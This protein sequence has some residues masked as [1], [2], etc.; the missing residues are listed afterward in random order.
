M[1]NE[2]KRRPRRFWHNV[3]VS[4]Y[5]SIVGRPK[6]WFHLKAMVF[7][8]VGIADRHLAL[9][10]INR[11]V[12]ESNEILQFARVKAKISRL[13]FLHPLAINHRHHPLSSGLRKNPR[14]NRSGKKRQK[15]AMNLS[16][17]DAFCR[18]KFAANCRLLPPAVMHTAA[19]T[20][21]VRRFSVR[22]L[23]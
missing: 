10:F 13:S 15:A 8:A 9:V 3:L 18:W 5:V 12:F 23:P 22:H 1:Q 19:V 7:C 6:L 2:S 4:R 17:Y 11:S 14:Q 21:E 16:Q 20:K